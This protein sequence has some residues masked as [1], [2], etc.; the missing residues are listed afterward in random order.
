MRRRP[1]LLMAVLLAVALP[2]GTASADAPA[3]STTVAHWESLSGPPQQGNPVLLVADVVTTVPDVGGGATITFEEVDGKAAPCQVTVLQAT[4]N[5]CGVGT[6]LIGT[7]TFRAVYSGNALV[8]G[9]VSDPFDLTIGANVIDATNVGASFTTFYPYRDGYRDTV[10]FRGDRQE[11]LSV[12]IRIARSSGFVVKTVHL[13]PEHDGPYSWSWDGR[14]ADGRPLASGTY[15]VSQTLTDVYGKFANFTM[16]VTISPKRLVTKVVTLEKSGNA[17]ASGSTGGSVLLSASA[18]TA[19]LAGSAAAGPAQAG[20]QFALPSATVYQG[21]TFQALTTGS[22]HT[23]PNRIGLQDFK[24]CA[25]VTGHWDIGCFDHWK[26]FPASAS[27]SA[28]WSSAG[29]S[30]TYDRY[31]R[32][33]RGMVAVATGTVTVDRVRLRVTYGVLE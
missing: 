25:L 5:V 28:V 27:S 4:H 9:S 11:P 24:T 29:G 7:Y 6:L 8:A 19:R 15:R 26:A 23:P 33:V 18:R 14:Y 17:V 10:T 12:V 2:T 20:Y 22:P 3:P 31:A 1:A 13:E 21:L 16:Q 30:V 32:T